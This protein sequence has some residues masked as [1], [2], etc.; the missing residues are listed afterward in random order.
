MAGVSQAEIKDLLITEFG[1]KESNFGPG[2][3]KKPA[4]MGI[5]AFY[6]KQKAQLPTCM[7]PV[8]EAQCREFV[9]LIQRSLFYLNLKYKYLQEKL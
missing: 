4:D 1:I 5:A 9:D 2:H 7:M 8:G 3:F 6:H